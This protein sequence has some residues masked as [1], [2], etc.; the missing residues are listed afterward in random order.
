MPAAQ[1]RMVP[2]PSEAPTLFLDAQSN[3]TPNEPPTVTLSFRLPPVK[4]WGWGLIASLTLLGLLLGAGLAGSPDRSH[5][6]AFD[7]IK[8]RQVLSDATGR[9]LAC[10]EEGIPDLEGSVELLVTPDGEVE[11][12]NAQGKLASSVR[13]ECVR[14]YFEAAEFEPFSGAPVRVQRRIAIGNPAES[15]N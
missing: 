2:T 14:D 1:P 15:A 13:I 7:P 11:A 3:D 9:S 4:K 5:L 12:F 6:A 8:A 10:F